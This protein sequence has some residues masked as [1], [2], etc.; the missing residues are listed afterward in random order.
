MLLQ[1]LNPFFFVIAMLQR[2]ICLVLLVHKVHEHRL[3]IV[4]LLSVPSNARRR[5]W[6]NEKMEES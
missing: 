4:G 3:A 1:N 2:G 5:E 6:V